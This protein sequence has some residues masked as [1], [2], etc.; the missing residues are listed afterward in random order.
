MLSGVA[1][2]KERSEQ[3]QPS[4]KPNNSLRRLSQNG[5]VVQAAGHQQSFRVDAEDKQFVMKPLD[6][7]EKTNYEEIWNN[8][9]GEPLQGYVAHFGGIMEVQV[10]CTN[11]AEGSSS[12]QKFMRLG[13]LL[14][15]LEDVMIMDCKM[16]WRTFAE[17]EAKSNKPRPDLFDRLKKLAPETLTEEEKQAG[18]ITKYKWMTTNDGLK[19]TK[20]YAFRVDGITSREGVRATA[21]ELSAIRTLDGVLPMLA[22]VLPRGKA[23]DN[24]QRK[25]RIAVARSL[26]AQLELLLVGLESSPFFKSHEFVGASLLFIAHTYGATVHLIDLAKT[27]P[28]PEGITVDHRSPWKM[29]NHEDG[30]LYGLE[31]LTDCWRRVLSELEKEDGSLVGGIFFCTQYETEMAQLQ[32]TLTKHGIDI[33]L[34]GLGSAK[35]LQELHCDIYIEKVASMQVKNGAVCRVAELVRAWITAEVGGINHVLMGKYPKSSADG[36]VSFVTKTFAK[37]MSPGQSWKEA[38]QKAL[39]TRFGMTQ[40]T[41]DT[42]FHILGGTY[43]LNLE[44]KTGSVEVRGGYP[45]LSSMYRIHEIDVIIKDLKSPELAAIGLPDGLDFVTV[46]HNGHFGSS[47]RNWTWMPRCEAYEMEPRSN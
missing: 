5:F 37:K 47:L 1:D 23:G 11:G 22:R 10:G 43:R 26:L 38:L 45:G 29:G 40:D 25:K 6:E 14:R 35:S 33:S 15:D 34:Y 12:T 24:L 9:S 42:H 7:T 17:A 13:N 30:F 41:V 44:E 16:G 4:M 20:Q 31:A 39:V 19:T 3:P 27:D 18:A 8:T 21:E 46:K 36:A 28:V 32:Q 2:E